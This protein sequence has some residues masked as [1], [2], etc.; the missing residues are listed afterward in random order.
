MANKWL[1]VKFGSKPE[2]AFFQQSLASF[3]AVHFCTIFMVYCHLWWSLL[4]LKCTIVMACHDL[5]FGKPSQ[6]AECCSPL[7]TQ[8]FNHMCNFY[9]TCSSSQAQHH[10][11]F[12]RFA[13]IIVIAFSAIQRRLLCSLSSL[14]FPAVH[15]NCIKIAQNHVPF[16]LN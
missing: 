14:L 11:C 12:L 16:S 7:Q 6:L 8:F 3:V 5:P 1:I 15:C 2:F 4:G 13:G 9:R 10:S